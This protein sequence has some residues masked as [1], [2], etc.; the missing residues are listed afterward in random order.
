MTG[1]TQFERG[2]DPRDFADGDA[3]DSVT[4]ADR[5]A[6][7]HALARD[8][9]HS[10]AERLA[11]EYQPADTDAENS[12]LTPGTRIQCDEARAESPQHDFSQSGLGEQY[13]RFTALVDSVQGEYVEATVTR[14]NPHARS[15]DP[16][17]ELALS[18]AKIR[19]EARWRVE[20]NHEEADAEG[21][22]S[23]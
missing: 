8:D 18:A 1:F 15:P 3:D 10:M 20:T 6:T 11:A 23:R 9:L 16:G 13:P 7:I 14:R 4:A 2:V 22:D 17:A 5:R 21:G 12:E 19:D